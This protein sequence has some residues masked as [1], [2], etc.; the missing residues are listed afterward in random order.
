L[1]DGAEQAISDALAKLAGEVA[2]EGKNAVCTN[3]VLVAEWS[4]TDGEHW[5]SR[6]WDE[7]R[8]VWQRD[9]LLHHALFSSNRWDEDDE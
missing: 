1:T 4:D 8:P 5:L 7:N 2:G 6:W 9:G 3:W